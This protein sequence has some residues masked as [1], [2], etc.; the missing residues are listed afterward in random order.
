MLV[1]F[2]LNQ[3]ECSADPK[4]V[5][6]QLLEHNLVTEAH[7]GNVIAVEISTKTGEGLQELEQVELCL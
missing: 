7:G 2:K 6:I 5:R 4:K 3:F 1:S